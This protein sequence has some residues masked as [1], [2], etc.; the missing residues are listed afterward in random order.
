MNYEKIAANILE[1]VGGEKNIDHVTHCATRLRFNLKDDNNADTNAIKKIKGVMGVSNSGGQY[2]VI[3]GNEVNNV[4]KEITKLGNFKNNNSTNSVKKG[5]FTTVLDTLSGVFT[6]I[7]PA[8]IGC[9]M[10]KAVLVILKSANMIQV[11]SQIYSI[12]TFISDSAYYFLPMLLAWSSAVKFKCNVGLAIA[13][14]GVLL[15]PSFSALMAE[16]NSV[17]FLGLPITK[18]T[19]TSSVI[20]II[21]AVW[22]MSYVEKFAEKYSPSVVKSILKPLIIMIVMAPITLIIIGPLGAIIGNYLAIAISAI[23]T[24]AGWLVSGI[25]GA[26]FPFLIMTGMH[27]SL[28]PIA[29][30]AYTTTGLEGIV[31]P[32]MLVHSFTQSAAALAVALKTKNKDLKQVATSTSMTAILGV[33]EPA[34]FGVNLRLKK[35]LLAVVL[36]GLAGG[37]YVGAFGVA[38][39]AMGVTG[40]ATLPAF[41]TENPSNLLHAI[42]GCIIGFVVT[43]ILTFV[44]GFEDVVDDEDTDKEDIKEIKTSTE[45][46]SLSKEGEITSP[47]K[48]EVVELSSIKDETFASGIM[49]KGIAIIPSEGKLVS[50]VNGKISAIFPTLHAVGITSE[51]GMEILI[52]IGM[53]TVQ[54][55][56]KYFKSSVKEGDN[57]K[58]GDLLIN[59]DINKIKKAG[60]EITTPVVVTNSNDYTDVIV[61]EKKQINIGERLITII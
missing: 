61:S 60:Y 16:G 27:Y 40:I 45:V 48:G 51:D 25:M 3:I 10:I 55:E 57:V 14:A 15:H 13:L 37:V 52:H 17:K 12:L 58:K 2:Q 32:G 29:I 20:P 53:D 31:G 35:P 56:G 19:Y 44:L 42:I 8:M 36:G 26:T 9:A 22:V 54:L 49:G 38:R 11:D 30:T 4:Y 41:I 23:N 46:K 28:G 24:H 34:M 50:P 1:L 43:F 47:L 5:K 33:T 18:A 21:M 6:P 7:L 39:S 59:F